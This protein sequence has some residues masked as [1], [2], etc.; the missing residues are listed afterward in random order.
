MPSDND[1]HDGDELIPCTCADECPS[2]CKGVK[3][4]CRAC[5]MAWND[6]LSEE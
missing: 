2:A 3:C 1:Y 6:F 5:W 4:F